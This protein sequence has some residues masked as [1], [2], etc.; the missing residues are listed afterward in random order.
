MKFLCINPGSTSTRI[1]VFTD[2]HAD[3]NTNVKHSS[4][5]LEKF[6]KIQDQLDYRFL[7]ISN[8]L[9]ENGID[10]STI[11]AV[12]G[13]GGALRPIEGGVYSINEAMLIDC[14]NGTYSEHPSNLGCQLALLFSEPLGVPSFVV[15]PP[16]IDE[17]DEGGKNNRTSRTSAHKRLSP[18][19]SKSGCGFYCRETFKR[20]QR[21]KHCNSPFGKRYF[22]DST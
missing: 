10:I 7:L 6:D 12:V 4:E 5:E 18:A 22:G 17:F 20:Y 14:R 8:A 2:D 21:F 19:Q 15:D 13:R 16:L 3:W 11:D 9:K 1:A